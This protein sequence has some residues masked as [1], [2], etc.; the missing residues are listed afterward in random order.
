MIPR[1]SLTGVFAVVCL[2]IFSDCCLARLIPF[3]DD[4]ED[5]DAADGNPVTWL[6]QAE[7]GLPGVREVLNGDYIHQGPGYFASFVHESS[8][9]P[10][11]PVGGISIRTQLRVLDTDSGWVFSSLAAG[12]VTPGDGVAAQLLWGGVGA[13]GELSLGEFIGGA[14]VTHASTRLAFNPVDTDVF[15]QLDVRGNSLSLTAWAEG[16]QKPGQP[17]LDHA[18]T[19]PPPLPGAFGVFINSGGDRTPRVAFRSY[20]AVPEPSTLVL[21]LFALPL[22]LGVMRRRKAL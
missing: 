3:S 7:G 17:Q 15:L 2:L 13:N 4:F 10:F 8:E 6:E 18:R 19:T 16:S 20:E 11:G 14:N 9:P 22:I 12:G 5:G 1:H 21:A